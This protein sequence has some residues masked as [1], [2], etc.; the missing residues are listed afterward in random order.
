[1][2]EHAGHQAKEDS[3]VVNLED[4]IVVGTSFEPR[5]MYDTQFYKW[6]E[7]SIDFGTTSNTASSNAPQLQLWAYETSNTTITLAERFEKANW[8]AEKLERL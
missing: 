2:A 6:S 3:H 5:A 7:Q 1:L 4:H 8:E